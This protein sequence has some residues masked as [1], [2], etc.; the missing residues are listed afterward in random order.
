[1]TWSGH[2]EVNSVIGSVP[3]SGTPVAQSL[4]L[5]TT[6]ATGD[7]VIVMFSTGGVYGGNAQTGNVLP[8]MTCTDNMGGNTWHLDVSG[9]D[10]QQD[11]VAVFSSTLVNGGAGFT[12]TV[13]P[14]HGCQT[15]IMVLRYANPGG[16]VSVESTSTN[17]TGGTPTTAVTAGSL[18]IATG[19]DLVICGGQ[20]AEEYDFTAG[21]GFTHQIYSDSAP[22]EI[23]VED[24]L[25]VTSGLNPA[26]TL[27]FHGMWQVA[28]VAYKYV[29]AVATP[30]GASLLLGM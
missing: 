24:Q 23:G 19:P 20:L 5:S 17:N 13:T 28:G 22:T 26:M 18:T 9:N 7:F 14:G 15:G 1:M 29:S 10:G 11:V 16:I 21:S 8:G 6:P 3:S 4:T 12:V 27:G 25:N 30:T 2:L